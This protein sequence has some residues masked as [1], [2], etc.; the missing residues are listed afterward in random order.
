MKESELAILDAIAEQEGIA[1]NA[2]MRYFLRWAMAEYQAGRLTI[3]VTETRA[4][5]IDM[6]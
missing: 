6:P 4:R 2:I 5:K 1:R 3:P